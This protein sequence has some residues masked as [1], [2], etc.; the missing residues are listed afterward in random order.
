MVTH[1]LREAL[2]VADDVTVLRRGRVTFRGPAARNTEASLA[3]A[4]FPDGTP[5]VSIAT[6]SPGEE[7]VVAERISIATAQGSLGIRDASFVLRRHEIVGIAAVEGAGH[8]ELLSALGALSRP[9]S[10]TLRLPHR[11]VVVPADRHR[12]GIILSM[13]LAENVALRGAGAARGRV[14]WDRVHERARALV[15]RFGVA[16]PSER[17]AAGTLSGGNQQ[18]MVVATA[19]EDPVD[20]VVADNPTRGLD[21]NATTFVHEQLRAAAAAGAAV[22]VHSSDVDEVLSLATKVLVVFHGTVRESEV[23]RDR[24]GSLMLGAV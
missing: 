4:M 11:V 13:S 1:K 12:D 19:L 6:V 9:V 2:S 17:V 15:Q 21:L 16:A 22:V 10:G 20:L 7:V 23:D 18:R 3:R 5:A 8:R 14:P 24:V